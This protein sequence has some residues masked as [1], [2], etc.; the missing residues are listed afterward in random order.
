MIDKK[1]LKILKYMYRS[2]KPAVDLKKGNLLL[3]VDEEQ[4]AFLLR[5]NLIAPVNEDGS[6]RI[7]VEGRGCVEEAQRRKDQDASVRLYLCIITIMVL[8]GQLPSAVVVF[9]WVFT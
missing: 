4:L 3:S 7:T 9:R 2:H 5:H 6:Y 8:L 1:C